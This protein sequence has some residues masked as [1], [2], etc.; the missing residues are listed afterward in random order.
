MAEQESWQDIAERIDKQVAEGREGEGF[1]PVKAKVTRGADTVLS[2][3][4]P[5]EDMA[6]LR[7]YTQKKGV[8]VSEFARDAIMKAIS[9]D[10]EEP[11]TGLL[12][13]AQQLAKLARQ[14]EASAGHAS[15]VVVKR[16]SQGKIVG[17][18]RSSAT[19]RSIPSAGAQERRPAE[20]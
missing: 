2:I 11:L 6:L 14:V 12:A 5:S 9:E 18:S 16:D 4:M 15:G 19:G 17:R 13:G 3:R 10:A 1:V 20:H 7:R 8:R